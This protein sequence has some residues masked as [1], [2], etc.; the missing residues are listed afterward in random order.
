MQKGFGP[1]SESPAHTDTS[2]LAKARSDLPVLGV[3]AQFGDDACLNARVFAHLLTAALKAR[4]DR[5]IGQLRNRSG[6]QKCAD[7]RTGQAAL[8]SRS[9]T[10]LARVEKDGPTPPF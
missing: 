2:L 7:S 5:E 8:G 3:L 1:F 10:A 4:N 6:Y 9:T